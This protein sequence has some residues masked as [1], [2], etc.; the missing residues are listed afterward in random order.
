M[1]IL[2]EYCRFGNL[3]E[4]MQK[5]RQHFTNLIS[6]VT[7]KID[8]NLIPNSPTSPSFSESVPPSLDQDGYLAPAAKPFVLSDPPEGHSAGTVPSS[9]SSTSQVAAGQFASN[10]MYSMNIKPATEYPRKES[11]GSED[12]RSSVFFKRKVSRLNSIGS[13]TFSDGSSVSY[14][15]RNRR[16]SQQFCH[17][18]LSPTVDMAAQSC[19][20]YKRWLPGEALEPHS[21]CVSCR[22][23]MC[24]AKDRCS[25]CSHLT[26]LQFQAYVKDAE[27][28][29]A[30][31]KKRAKSSGGSSEKHSHWQELVY[32]CRV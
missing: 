24:S 3:L 6:P 25:E 18:A 1:L 8:P 9:N 2:V 7:G 30:K 26:L 32:C 11:R 12:H 15:L 29:S 27:K 28:R 13:I 22:P 20:G 19:V 5:R 16:T 23:T 10:P 21:C 4:F 17:S 31:K 14:P